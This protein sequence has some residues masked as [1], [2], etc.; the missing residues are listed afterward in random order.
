MGAAR[1]AQG[2][3]DLPLIDGDSL[4]FECGLDFVKIDVEGYEERVLKGLSKTIGKWNPYI[5]VETRANETYQP[6]IDFLSD[7]NYEIVF[8][9]SQYDDVI[10]LM[11]RPQK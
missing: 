5:Y 4:Y 1:I 11:M 9:Y 6:V 2:D 3:G 10:N 7:L 8:E